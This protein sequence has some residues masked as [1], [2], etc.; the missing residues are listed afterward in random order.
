VVSF[1]GGSS[2]WNSISVA[3]NHLIAS[4]VKQDDKSYLV[5]IGLDPSRF[6]QIGPFTESVS[7]TPVFDGVALPNERIVDAVDGNLKV[8]GLDIL[9]AST[10]VGIV[11]RNQI[12]HGEINFQSSQNIPIHISSIVCAPTANQSIIHTSV[13]PEDNATKNILK[14]SINPINPGNISTVLCVKFEYGQSILLAHIP[15]VGICQ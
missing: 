9:P 14:Y 1:G 8:R 7:L 4:V 10:F 5:R 13:V 12:F 2:K 11:Q 3:T 6:T 15:I